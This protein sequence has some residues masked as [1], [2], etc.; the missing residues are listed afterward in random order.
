MNVSRNPSW[1]TLVY[2]LIHER[3]WLKTEEVD[4]LVANIFS[5]GPKI[6]RQESRSVNQA[7]VSRSADSISE[8]GLSSESRENKQSQ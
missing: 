6:S 7:R 8:A 1:P 4:M 2:E 3:M 5:L